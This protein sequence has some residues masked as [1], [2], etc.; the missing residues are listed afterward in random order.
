MCVL[1]FGNDICTKH[2]V[3]ILLLTT[4]FCLRLSQHQGHSVAGTIMSMKKSN[5]NIGNEPVTFR[6]VAQFL[7]QLRHRVSHIINNVPSKFCSLLCYSQYGPLYK[8]LCS[9]FIVRNDF[10]F[11]LWPWIMRSSLIDLK[12][13][14][15]YGWGQKTRNRQ[16]TELWTDRL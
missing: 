6:F 11:N 9:T 7:N 15:G 14:E 3:V 8:L 2:P 10:L 4:N 5:D 13:L 1:K 16:I 12:V